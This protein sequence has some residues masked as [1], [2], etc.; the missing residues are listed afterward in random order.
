MKRV[1]RIIQNPTYQQYL[2][3]NYKAEKGRPYCHH[4]FFHQLTVARLAYLLILEQG[5]NSF[6]REI[7][8]AAGLLHD[9]GRW[10]QYS[11]DIDHPLAGAE[12]AR[13][14]LKNAGF[15][16]EEIESITK[17]I[18]EHGS[19]GLKSTLLGETLQRADSLARTC[20]YCAA[21]DG[22]KKVQGQPHREELIY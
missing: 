22:C 17:A 3:W 20:F 12:L 8:Y 21:R 9:I 1:N 18:R 13:P 16:A 11:E 14:L 4:D 6:S 5:K 2:E 15:S 10:R 19:S 7:I